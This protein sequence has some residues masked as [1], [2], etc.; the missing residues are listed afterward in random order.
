MKM[1]LLIYKSRVRVDATIRDNSRRDSCQD[2]TVVSGLLRQTH[3]SSER[4]LAEIKC[5]KNR[6][7]RTGARL[8]HGKGISCVGGGFS[9]PD[10]VSRFLQPRL[11]T[12][13]VSE[14]ATI[15]PESVLQSY[16]LVSCA[17]QQFND[18]VSTGGQD[19]LL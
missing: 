13:S 3:I 19:V 18:T 7:F 11:G 10:R 12:M 4:C 2:P 6:R 16:A 15:P 5:A 17:L 14:W 8:F 1:S 9:R